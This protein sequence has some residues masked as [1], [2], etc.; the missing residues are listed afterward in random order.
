MI[1]YE[2]EQL[3]ICSLKN[4][5]LSPLPTRVIERKV[6]GKPGRWL[7]ADVRVFGNFVV[8]NDVTP[9]SLKPLN[10][11]PGGKVSARVLRMKMTDDLSGVREYRC[12][13]NG[14][15]VLAEFDGKYSLL[16]IDLNQVD[17]AVTNLDLRL[18]L[19]DCCGNES[20]LS[21]QLRR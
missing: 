18:F 19:T 14:E 5:K 3:V 21:Y 17:N 16:T 12:F 11:K 8:A 1:G 13:I 6:E 9:P 4:D 15:W 10:F 7:E 20:E 2:P